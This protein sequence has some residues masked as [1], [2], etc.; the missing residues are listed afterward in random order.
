MLNRGLCSVVGLVAVATFLSAGSAATVERKLL[1]DGRTLGAWTPAESALSLET[2]A[3]EPA[4]RF[5]VPVDWSAGEQNYPVGWPR[6][7]LRLPDDSTD[8]RQWDQLRL[9]VYA[10]PDDPPLPRDPIGVALGTGERHSSWGR[11]A[12]GL[13]RGQWTDFAFDLSDVPNRDHVHTVTIYIS[14]EAYPDGAKLRFYISALELV[15]YLQPTLLALQSSPTVAFADAPALPLTLRVAGVR[16]GAPARLPIALMRGNA[17]LASAAVQVDEGLTTVTFPLPAGTPPGDYT[18]VAG[19]GDQA[20][21]RPLR[22]VAS[23]WQEA[24]Q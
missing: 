5:Y 22:L 3:G 15:R 13:P 21:S 8:W 17:C 11:V 16:S 9:R 18:L 1:I 20:I 2:V 7:S 4:F 24:A 19:A 10:P 6:I 23:P 12:E 14:E